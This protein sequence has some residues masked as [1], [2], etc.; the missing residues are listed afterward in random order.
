MSVDQRYWDLFVNR[1]DAYAVQNADGSYSSI[2]TKLT[3]EILFGDKTIGLYQ[4][5]LES[6]VK[7]A[8]LDIDIK[9]KIAKD[10]PN[11]DI[12]KWDT[13][14]KQQVTEASKLLN[15][16][17][18]PHYIEFSGFRGYHIWIFFDEPTLANVVKPW[19]HHTFDDMPKVNEH[20]EWELFPKQKHLSGDEYGSL[21]KVPLQI[22]QKSGNA[23]YFVD[24]NF[25]KI[26]GLPDIATCTLDPVAVKAATETTKPAPKGF[27]AANATVGTNTK[28]PVPDNIAKML[29]NCQQ[30]NDI[31]SK[32][33]NTNH[34]DNN[35]RVVL[36]SLGRFFGSSGIEWVHSVMQNCNDYNHDTTDYHIS[37]MTHNPVHCMK[38]EQLRKNKLCDNC[39]V[40]GNTPL[41]LGYTRVQQHFYAGQELVKSN[42]L[43]DL[44]TKLGLNAV[45]KSNSFEVSFNTNKYSIDK[46]TGSWLGQFNIIDFI[47]Y[48]KPEDWELF[49]HQN[50]PELDVDR[51][52]LE[53]TDKKIDEIFPFK[54]TTV[55][56]NN[57]LSE[58][59]KE[60]EQILTDDK[61]YNM[62]AYTGFGKTFALIDKVKKNKLNAIFLTPYESTAKQLENIYKIPSVYGTV[63]IDE[64]QNHM[65]KSNIVA[66]TYDGLKKIL[67]TRM[68]PDDYILLIDEAHNLVTHSN[69]RDA[70][71]TTILDNMTRFKKIIN[72]SGTPE[73]VLNND[74]S[75]IKFV[76]QNQKSLISN[77]TI[78]D[79]H[80]DTATACVEHIINNPPKK[81]KVVIFRNFIKELDVLRAELIKRGVKPAQIKILHANKKNESLFISIVE[82]EKIP[83]GV[84][85]VLTTS[86]IS[87]GVNIMNQHIETVYMLEC[88]NLIM[89]RQF[90]ARFRKGVQNVYD[91][92]PHPK[93]NV[94]SIKWFDFTVELKRLVALYEKIAEEKTNFLNTSGLIRATVNMNFIQNATGNTNKELDF[95]R[96]RGKTGLIV[97]NHQKL[98]LDFLNNFNQVA[99]LD[100]VKR[101][102][103]LDHFLGLSCNTDVLLKAKVDLTASKAKVKDRAQKDRNAMINF[104]SKEPQK[105][106]TTYLQQVNQSLMKRIKDKIGGLYDPNLS[107]LDFFNTNKRVLTL[108]DSTRLIE[109]YMLF[110]KYHFSHDFI[111]TLL[112][113]SDAEIYE[114]ELGYHTQLNL[115]LVK[116]HSQI[117]R[118]NKKSLQVFHYAVFKFIY[119]YFQVHKEFTYDGLLHELNTYLLT[120]KISN[121]KMDRNKM[122]DLVNRMV[123]KTR[124]Q[125]RAGADVKRVGWK[126]EG[127]KEISDLVDKAHEQ[128]VQD[129]ITRYLK[130]K[131]EFMQESIFISTFGSSEKSDTVL[132][133]TVAEMRKSL[134]EL[135]QKQSPQKND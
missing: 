46:S 130:G 9:K 81:G 37:K 15:A 119:D 84:K 30:L 82:D 24:E 69:F 133:Q 86:V 40:K 58:A 4:L 3:S 102:E 111:I 65:R 132:S 126:F 42:K 112:K 105:T 36:A 79:T 85:Y 104:L 59:D 63:S 20:F 89:L 106:I 2:K 50:Y 47:R 26:D 123:K 35:E 68:I 48:V 45:E 88:Q 95:L 33:E 77:Y 127:F 11:F 38:I 75:N 117:L 29:A 124:L 27:T 62:I 122:I 49:I 43:P 39:R 76:K 91:F 60:V 101:K 78:V 22:H 5:N 74:Y 90:I 12:A 93:Y 18:I 115:E 34:L 109:R 114:F 80:E 53:R 64:V 110:H 67:E 98:T 128:M 73:G 6:K 14:L 107:T 108:K 120:K 61:N 7:W 72:I 97:V 51:F 54:G 96:E 17:N 135:T 66:A 113:K 8:V 56:F 100:L 92:I 121:Q 118:Y 87:D 55:T 116:N 23:T 94:G 1:D 57:Y 19:M 32:A 10:D 134:E 13:L 70:A 21:V 52:A 16:Q 103:Y 99:Y 28:F 71:L 131:A 44:F 83:A 125:K 129:S 31:V 41:T 25:N